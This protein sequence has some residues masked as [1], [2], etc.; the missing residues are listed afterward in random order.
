VAGPELRDARRRRGG[1]LPGLEHRVV[2]AGRQA[3]LQSVLLQRVDLEVDAE[4][5]QL[6][7]QQA[8][9]LLAHVAGRHHQQM[10]GELLTVA[11]ADAVRSHPP[12]VRGE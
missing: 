1:R 3:L 9:V 5:A 4:R 12:A 7:L 2:L 8:R 6:R 10:E 11:H